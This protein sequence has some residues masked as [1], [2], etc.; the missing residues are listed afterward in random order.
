MRIEC[1]FL[2]ITLKLRICCGWALSNTKKILE[3]NKKSSHLEI[4]WW[5]HLLEIEAKSTETRHCTSQQWMNPIH[6]IFLFSALKR[7]KKLEQNILNDTDSLI[8]ELK[9]CVHSVKHWEVLLVV[10]LACDGYWS[11]AVM[12]LWGACTSCENC[13]RMWSIAAKAVQW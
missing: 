6:W 8:S 12:D 10:S 9:V 11:R 3:G 4:G 1:R 5:I 13:T 2:C 7:K